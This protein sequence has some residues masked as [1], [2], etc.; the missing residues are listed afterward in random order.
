MVYRVE[1]LVELLFAVVNL[2]FSLLF[3][4]KRLIFGIFWTP[5]RMSQPGDRAALLSVL[6]YVKFIADSSTDESTKTQ[7]SVAHEMLA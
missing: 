4:G 7:L 5:Q 2:L 3:P 6:E 1:T